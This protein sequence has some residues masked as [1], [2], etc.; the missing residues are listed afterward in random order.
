MNMIYAVYSSIS[1]STESCVYDTENFKDAVNWAYEHSRDDSTIEL[2]AYDDES[3]ELVDFAAKYLQYEDIWEGYDRLVE[4]DR[5]LK[6]RPYDKKL[7]L[8]FHEQGALL[9]HLVERLK[10]HRKK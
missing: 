10:E 9:M 7:L 1:G 4:I 8:E 5:A 6:G 3:Y 2:R